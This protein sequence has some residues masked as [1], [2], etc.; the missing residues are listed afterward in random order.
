MGG[1]LSMKRF[2]M[3]LGIVDDTILFV[4]VM[5]AYLMSVSHS[6]EMKELYAAGAVSC[7]DPDDGRNMS[8]E[9]QN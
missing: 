5:T 6:C 4:V 7:S 9:K 2:R 1:D 8:K 3:K